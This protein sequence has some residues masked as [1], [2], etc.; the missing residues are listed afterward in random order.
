MESSELSCS[1]QF[2]NFDELKKFIEKYE[3]QNSVQLYVSNSTKLSSV[4]YKN[5]KSADPGLVYYAIQYRCVHGGNFESSSKGMR[6]SSTL[7]QGCSFTLKFGLSYDGKFLKLK[8]NETEH[9]HGIDSAIFNSMPRQRRLNEEEESQVKTFLDMR[10]NKRLVKD[11][12]KTKM[13]KV[14]LLKDLSNIKTKHQKCELHVNTGMPCRHIFNLLENNGESIFQPTL[15]KNKFKKM[16]HFAHLVT[17]DVAH[18]VDEADD[19]P[20][21]HQTSVNANKS[22]LDKKS[23]YKKAMMLCGDIANMIADYGTKEF[24]L[25]M[26]TLKLMKDAVRQRKK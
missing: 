2:S 15:V 5:A 1:M 8:K 21:I 23:K 19:S 16:D 7:R 17:R 11:Y 26:E 13:N 9:S 10:C 18:I 12:I 22:V 25:I 3:Q 4:Q 6:K 14:V 20:K 24:E